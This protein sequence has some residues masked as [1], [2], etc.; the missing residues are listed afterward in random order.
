MKGLP[1]EGLWVSP[2]GER[3]SVI[4][5]L[6]TIQQS[7]EF[8]GLTKRKVHGA[9]I[10]DLRNVAEELIRAGWLRFRFFPSAYAF[11]VDSAKRRMDEIE[12]ILVESDAY[13]KEEVVISQ[14]I[15]KKEF[16]G[17]VKDVYDR[18]ILGYYANPGR[19]RWRVT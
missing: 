19:N 3:I 14:A 2:E 9:S 16:K 13:E 18:T 5:H 1:L 6:I 12:K 8:F 17:V 4:E 15:P 10:S 11:E 7:P